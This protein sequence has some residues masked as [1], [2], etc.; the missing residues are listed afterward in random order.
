MSDSRPLQGLTV[1][2][3]GQLLA[4]PFCGFMLAGFGATVIKVEPPGTG[5][6]I[7]S[8]RVL[9]DDGT[10]LWWRSLA[11]DKYSVTADLRREAGREIVRDL[12]RS[13][14]DVVIE[15]FRPGRMEAWDLGPDDLHAIDPRVILVRISGYGQDGPY[16][17]RPGFANIAE[18]FAGFRHLTA[19]PGRP[20]VRGGVSL[21]DTTA[22]LHAAYATLAAV[23]ER[24]VGGSGKGQ[25]IDVALYE[26]MFNMM[27]S[28]LPE[29]DRKGVVRQPTGGALPG[30]V[31]SNTYACIDGRI[32]IGANSTRLFVALMKLI[33]RADLAEDPTLAT[34]D[35]RSARAQLLDE[36]IEAWTSTRACADALEALRDAEVPSG[37]INTIADIAADPHVQARAMMPKLPLPSGDMLRV[38]A[39]VPKMSRT[40]PGSRWLGPELGEHNL[41]IYGTRLGYDR[42]TL[43]A[44]REAEVI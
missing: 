22:G 40:P 29:Y 24:D 17:A 31:P 37:P 44:L 33:G 12:I 3:L 15:N 14:V 36:A 19:E 35:G 38:P 1:L 2:E 9:D 32:V 21:G 43:E 42:E 25:V 8:W 30:I 16:A 13:G 23:Y 34:N 28:L 11:R 26:S 4:G 27:E 6:A 5:D 7:R 39:V 20:P 18:A 41:E 10:S